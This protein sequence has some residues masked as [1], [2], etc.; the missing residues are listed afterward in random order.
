MDRNL[1]GDLQ[2]KARKLARKITVAHDLDPEIQEELYGYI[3]DKR[4]AYDG[5]LLGL[6]RTPGV[7]W[8]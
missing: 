6:L 4:R 7:A 3:E 1:E 2:Q 5:E 8:G